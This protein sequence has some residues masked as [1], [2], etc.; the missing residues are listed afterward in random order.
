M[1]FPEQGDPLIDRGSQ[2]GGLDQGGIRAPLQDPGDQLPLGGEIGLEDDPAPSDPVGRLRPGDLAEP[3]V[4]ALDQPGDPLLEVDPGPTDR[5]A[6]L[7]VGQLGI[8]AAVEVLGRLEVVLGLRRVAHLS[9]DPGEAEDPDRFPFVGETDQ[10]ELPAPEDQV[11]GVDLPVG[12][13]VAVH[14]VVA[15]GDRLVA[16]DRSLDPGQ[17]LGRLPRARSLELG[18]RDGDRPGLGERVRM[19]PGHLLEGEPERLGIGELTFGQQRERGAKG[20]QLVIGEL[21]RRKVEVLR[22]EGVELGLEEAL[23]RP[24]D[25]ELD[26]EAVELGPIGIEATGKCVLVHHAVALD[27]TLDLERRDRPPLGHQERDQRKLP[28]QLLGVFRHPAEDTDGPNPAIAPNGLRCRIFPVFSCSWGRFRVFREPPA[29]GMPVERRAP[30]GGPFRP[31]RR[32][33]SLR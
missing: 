1:A 12:D 28:N 4:V 16:G 2:L 13:L 29:G 6:Q 18:H 11:V 33:H 14:R 32:L 7:P 10:V 25:L 30:A 5:L 26:P 17:S 21:D 22:R 27:L 15:E 31:L 3:P 24:I 9:L 20:S 23:A 19:A 8:V